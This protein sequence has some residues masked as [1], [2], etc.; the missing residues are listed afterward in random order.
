[1]HYNYIS[2]GNV[3]CHYTYILFILGICMRLLSWGLC[4]EYKLQL[5]KIMQTIIIIIIIQVMLPYERLLLV[6]NF[7]NC[8]VC[9]VIIKDIMTTIITKHNSSRF[10]QHICIMYK[11]N[12]QKSFQRVCNMYK[13]IVYCIYIIRNGNY[14]YRSSVI[15]TIKCNKSIQQSC[16]FSLCRQRINYTV[17]Y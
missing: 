12:L 14:T 6:V 16:H 15:A 9:G 8:I 11:N 4:R 3:M 7:C 17:S 10:F 13:Y 2:H 5:Q 1:M